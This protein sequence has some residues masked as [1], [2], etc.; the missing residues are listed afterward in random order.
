MDWL[1]LGLTL[2]IRY[3]SPWRS[4]N[5]CGYCIGH[6]GEQKGLDPNSLP[7][8]QTHDQSLVLR[9]DLGIN[10]NELDTDS[11]WPLEQISGDAY[12][13][14]CHGAS[15]VDFIFRGGFHCCHPIMVGLPNL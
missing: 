14:L 8:P 2:G 15:G 5:N 13:N 9:L 7:V 3:D 4:S 12:T 6:Y 10:C 1:R 11:S